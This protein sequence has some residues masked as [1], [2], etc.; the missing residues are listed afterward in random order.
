MFPVDTV[1][2]NLTKR[3]IR[4]PIRNCDKS[5]TVFARLTIFY[6]LDE[7]VNNLFVLTKD[8]AEFV[9]KTAVPDRRDWYLNLA[10]DLIGKLSPHPEPLP[11]FGPEKRPLENNNDSATGTPPPSK[12]VRYFRRPC[13]FCPKLPEAPRHATF[14]FNCNSAVCKKHRHL[15]CDSCSKKI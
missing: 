12:K 4:T 14:C 5:W 6:Y 15:V 11:V 3:T 1:D 8:N 9:A 2:Q 10:R 13:S 7:M